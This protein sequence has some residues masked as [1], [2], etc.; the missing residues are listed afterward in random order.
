MYSSKN[1]SSDME[2]WSRSKCICSGVDS[3][4]EGGDVEVLPEGQTQHIQVLAA[5]SKRTGQRDEDYRE[6]EE[7]QDA[8]VISEVTS[9]FSDEAQQ[10]AVY[11]NPQRLKT[12]LL[13]LHH[14]HHMLHRHTWN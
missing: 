3:H 1:I 2:K 5:V 10:S 14:H 8:T 11:I 12:A 7:G 4:L 9:R 6:E 13:N